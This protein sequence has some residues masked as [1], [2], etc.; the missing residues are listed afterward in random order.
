MAMAVMGEGFV[1]F[2]CCCL[3]VNK[4]GGNLVAARFQLSRCADLDLFSISIYLYVR[5]MYMY[6]YL[7]I[8]EYGHV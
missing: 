7:H 8:C 1:W 2:R 6:V 3:N 5:E 4:S